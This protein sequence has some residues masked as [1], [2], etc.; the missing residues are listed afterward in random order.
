MLI[1][2]NLL[3]MEYK[4]DGNVYLG[5]VN[6]LLIWTKKIIIINVELSDV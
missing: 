5:N 1:W 2:A 4:I 3:F 6:V